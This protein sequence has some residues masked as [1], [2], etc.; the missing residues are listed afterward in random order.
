MAT[1]TQIINTPNKKLDS[2]SKIEAITKKVN[3]AR[4]QYGNT[5]VEIDAP[6][7]Q[8]CEGLVAM[9]YLSDADKVALAGKEVRNIR[10]QAIETTECTKGA[11]LD[12]EVE[13]LLSIN[14]ILTNLEASS[15]SDY[16]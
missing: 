9:T 14:P 7:V 8:T 5:D 3:K 1:L 11:V 16:I 12:R 15:N 4:K 6:K 2:A 10:I 13:R